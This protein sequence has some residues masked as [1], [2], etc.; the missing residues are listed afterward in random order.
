MGSD[1]ARL[2]A[3]DLAALVRSGEGTAAEEA[4]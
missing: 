3:V 2:D 4:A 1:H